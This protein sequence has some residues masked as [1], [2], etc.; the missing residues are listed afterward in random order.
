VRAL[1]PATKQILWGLFLAL[2][3]LAWL[4]L[5]QLNIEITGPSLTSNFMDQVDLQR[6]DFDGYEIRQLL[7]RFAGQYKRS[8]FPVWLPAIPLA[9]GFFLLG[10]GW[11][12]RKTR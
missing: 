1:K 7:G 6:T 8:I 2:V 4:A 11:R 10:S 3:G 5:I 9:I 12:L